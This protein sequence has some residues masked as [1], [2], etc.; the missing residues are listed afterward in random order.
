[1]AGPA[2]EGAGIPRA[3][4]LIAGKY[5]V[6]DEIGAG[7]MGVVVAATHRE[8]GQRVAIKFLLPA[9]GGSEEARA[10]FVR[11]ARAVASLESEHIVRVLD[12]GS[13]PDQTPYMVMQYLAGRDLLQELKQRGGKLAQA[14]AVDYV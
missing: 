13:L 8:L 3:G 9:R 4:E 2:R 1:M 10:R 14:E 7:A 12:F 6:G 11:E 5:E